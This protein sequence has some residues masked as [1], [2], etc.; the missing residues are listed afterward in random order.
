M[1]LLCGLIFLVMY[2][3]QGKIEA[4]ISDL[5]L[6]TEYTKLGSIS[7]KTRRTLGLMLFIGCFILMFVVG[8][9]SFEGYLK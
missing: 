5:N 1:T 6:S 2:G 4:M 3:L 9:F 8:V 7:K